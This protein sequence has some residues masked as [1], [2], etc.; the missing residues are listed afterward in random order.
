MA[1]VGGTTGDFAR[2][3]YEGRVYFFQ[4]VLCQKNQQ[5]F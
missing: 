2:P 4:E 1:N 5:L 3:F